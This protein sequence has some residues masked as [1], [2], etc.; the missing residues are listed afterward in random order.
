MASTEQV[1][2][3]LAYWFQLGKKVAV[4]GGS[5]TLLPRPVL[6]GSRYSDAFEQCWQHIESAPENCHLEGTEQTIAQLLDPAWEIES[7][8]R[9]DMPVPIVAVGIQP[10]SCPCNDLPSWPD[11]EL[12]KPRSPVNERRQLDLIRDRLS[13][14]SDRAL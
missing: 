7:C 4:D 8:A 5:V 10:L 2:Q 1:K 14:S 11:T 9:C 6:Q 13:R 12:P 3:Y